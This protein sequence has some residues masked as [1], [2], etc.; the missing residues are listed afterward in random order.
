MTTSALVGT[1][2]GLTTSA[3][4][5]LAEGSEPSDTD[6]AVVEGDGSI[7]ASGPAFDV[8][9]ERVERAMPMRPTSSPT[10]TAPTQRMGRCFFL[11]GATLAGAGA[12]RTTTGAGRPWPSGR[13]PASIG[14]GS[15][16]GG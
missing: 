13:M 12:G 5:A 11:G 3:P 7:V 1:S 8:G 10:T 14:A 4:S 15:Q 2:S 16:G 9:D 6:G